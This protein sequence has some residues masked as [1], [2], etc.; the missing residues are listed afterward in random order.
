MYFELCILKI[1]GFAFCLFF[2]S[3]NRI[4]ICHFYLSGAKVSYLVQFFEI[5]RFLIEG[6]LSDGAW[7]SVVKTS[8]RSYFFGCFSLE[9]TAFITAL[10]FVHSDSNQKFS[11]F[12]VTN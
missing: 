7:L 6:S 5:L 10:R 4:A 12:E 9:V 1:E 11:I 2:D 8:L 3:D